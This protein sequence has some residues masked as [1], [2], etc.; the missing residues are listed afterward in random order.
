MG[1]S[2]FLP[3]LIGQQQATRLLL[4]GDVIKGPEA[5]DI[6][7]ILRT[8]EDDSESACVEDAKVLAKTIT[9]SGL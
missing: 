1:S 9:S 2:F 3:K 6:G 4:S 8:V 7:L 5:A